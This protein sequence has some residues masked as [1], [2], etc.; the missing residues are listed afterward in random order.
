MARTGDPRKPRPRRLRLLESPPKSTLPLPALVPVLRPDQAVTPAQDALLTG[1]ARRAR[2]GDHVARDLL[3]RAF[4]PRL[5]PAVLRCGWLT[6]QAGWARRD[7]RPWELDDVR[8]EAWLVFSE[9]VEG[10]HGENSFIPYTTAFFPWRLRKAIRRLGPQRRAVPIHLA[11]DPVVDYRGLLDAEAAELLESLAA[12]LTPEEADVLRMRIGE[13]SGLA[14]IACRLDVSRRTV[15]R[16]WK[17]I[18]IVARTVLSDSA[19]PAGE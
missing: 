2:L 3:W 11:G 8:Q 19:H 4:A 17:R 15:S 7:G 5:E 1:I 18:R 12:A 14:D 13:G 16:R 6:W 10:W 9:L